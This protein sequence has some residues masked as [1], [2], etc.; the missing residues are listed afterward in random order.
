MRSME[1]FSKKELMQKATTIIGGQGAYKQ[2]S[3]IEVDGKWS[4]IENE[5]GIVYRWFDW[6]SETMK[7]GGKSRAIVRD[8]GKYNIV[9]DNDNLLCKTWYDDIRLERQQS[10][11]DAGSRFAVREGASADE[12][13]ADLLKTLSHED[14]IEIMRTPAKEYFVATLNGNTIKLD[15]WGNAWD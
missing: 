13:Y 1:K 14:V 9:D 10:S 2:L 8:N 6:H 7:V 12:K 3:L 15:K 5:T 11:K 4:T